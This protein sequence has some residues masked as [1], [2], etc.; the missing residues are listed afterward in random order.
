M[1]DGMMDES[2]QHGTEAGRHCE[3]CG[4]LAKWREHRES[5]QGATTAELQ[6]KVAELEAEN[7]RLRDWKQTILG[8][9]GDPTSIAVE[10]RGQRRR[11][12]AVSLRHGDE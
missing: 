4:G 1:F 12:R 11:V 9:N 5:W 7:S 3:K 10:R 2:C 6:A 8:F